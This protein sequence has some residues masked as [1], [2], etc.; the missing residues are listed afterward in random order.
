MIRRWI[1]SQLFLGTLSFLVV[2]T[3][4]AWADPGD[5]GTISISSLNQEVNSYAFLLDDVDS[6]EVALTV[7]NLASLG[8]TDGITDAGVL[9]LIIQMQGA[10]IVSE[11]TSNYGNI[12]SLN[13]AGNYEFARVESVDSASNTV[14]LQLPLRN[15]YTFDGHTQVVRVPEYQDLT[16]TS[17]GS[18]RARN[19]DGQIGGVVAFSVQG[20]LILDGSVDAKGR[21][22]RGGQ[23]DMVSSPVTTDSSLF[24][25]DQVGEGGGL[26]GESVAGSEVEYSALGG[27][28]GR[29]A[30][31]NGGGGG[32][33]F[34]AGGGGGAN[35]NNGSVW[36]G[37]GVMDANDQTF[38]SL[39]S[40]VV[41][42]NG[43][44]LSNSSGGGRGGYT[45][46]SMDQDAN[47][48]PPGDASWGANQRRERGGWGG[49]PFAGNTSPE[50]LSR[51]FCGGGGGS[52]ASD[53][54]SSGAGGRG[55]GIVII[56]ARDIQSSAA[57]MPGRI[58]IGGNDGE[59]ASGSAGAG[60]GG[61]GGTAVVIAGI[62][63]GFE[64]L[65]GGGAGGDQTSAA[66][67]GTGPGGG[68]GGGFVALSTENNQSI[69]VSFAGALGGESDQPD[70]AE[71]PENGASNGA[72]GELFAS[73]FVCEDF[74]FDCP[75]DLITEVA[76]TAPANNAT[77]ADASPLVTG[78]A[79]PGAMVEVI[80]DGG[81]PLGPVTVDA[82]GDWQLQIT[83]VLA[84]GAHTIEAR[85]MDSQGNQASVQSMFTVDSLGTNTDTDGDGLTDNEE[86]PGGQ[87]QDTD[88]DNT[89]N[90]LD[91]DDDG[92][93]ILTSDERPN[94]QNRDTDND[95]F[96]DHLDNDD[97]DDGLLTADERP[98]NQDQ[99]TDGD[100][101]PNHLDN[102]DDGDGLLTMLERPD[103]QNIDINTNG[104]PDHLDATAPFGG[105]GGPRG[106]ALCSSGTFQ[107]AIPTWILALMGLLFWLRRRRHCSVV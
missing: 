14:N 100:N 70:I 19:W 18:I 102:D 85:A 29:G 64:V 48:V 77:I 40:F 8:L 32:N 16:V 42:V 51:V 53:D 58:E 96:P 65:A 66:A 76:I 20:T 87:D 94:G 56:V 82:N 62:M 35:G 39:D 86:R 36:N 67:D 12:S 45:A 7:S 33:S 25:S 74:P 28:Y 3:S 106:G 63:D 99:D 105:N 22:F 79:E 6:G 38:W 91:N 73:S 41:D 72:S 15:T 13:G 104:I 88:G 1:K 49:R 80:V 71:W 97:D 27:Q 89:P 95:G 75:V 93:D 60:G 92:D 23:S 78:T 52:G 59:D 46:S 44:Q 61:A 43:N 24:V 81:A 34:K 11:N 103:G 101:T 69:T 107:G 54:A 84:E 5:D 55:G 68:G 4:K 9:L 2:V 30:P 47:M 10:D 31:A 83:T 98:D 26:K 90:H 37:Q 50:P 57:D 21:C 17:F